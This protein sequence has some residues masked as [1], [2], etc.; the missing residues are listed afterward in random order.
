MLVAFFVWYCLP[1]NKLIRSVDV[2]GYYAGKTNQVCTC[3]PVTHIGG[4]AITTIFYPNYSF[5]KIKPDLPTT[6]YIPPRLN[7]DN[8]P[9]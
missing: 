7:I 5:Y 8:V 2:C 6:K 1:D 9:R 4:N 3:T